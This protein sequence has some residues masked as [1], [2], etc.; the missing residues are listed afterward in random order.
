[1]KLLTPLAL[2]ALAVAS[3]TPQ[4][5]P[6]PRSLPALPLA[7][8][9]ELGDVAAV[10]ELSNG[11]LLI[12]DDATPAILVV[13]LA[14]GS[15]RKIGRQGRGPNEFQR[16]GGI[17]HATD[18]GVAFVVDR[19]QPRVFVIDRNGT[20]T[21]MRS[22]EQRGVQSSADKIDPRRIDAA[23]H[24]YF[25][26]QGALLRPRPGQTAS[27]SA[28]LLRFD[29]ARQHADTVARLFRTRPTS[30]TTR[31]RLTLSRT[32]IF[33]PADGWA[34]IPDGS[35]AVVRAVPY[36][37]DWFAPTGQMSVGQPIAYAPVKVTDAD[38]ENRGESRASVSGGGTSGSG[39]PMGIS[40]DTKPE[41]ASVKPA[42][43]PEAIVVGPDSRVWVGRFVAAESKQVVYDAF[44]RRGSRVDRIALPARSRLVGFGPN[45]VY[46]V[47]LD[48]DD[49][50]HL[51]KYR[52]R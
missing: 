24:A 9:I 29:P 47:E 22:I 38:R 18:G 7:L 40:S 21:A 16:P 45:A 43:D 25:V 34:V 46:A 37:V 31:D 13:D 26:D 44:D 51:R 36:R 8:T 11:H 19:S 1:M 4:S 17:Y 35:I 32:P 2:A 52:L 5:E 41:F 20:L 6:A 42:F 15:V 10:H 30:I 14:S 33:S 3:T 39:R 48:D 28:A 23:L 12:S 49:E 50:P 27:D